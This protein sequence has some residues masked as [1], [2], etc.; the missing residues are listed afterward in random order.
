MLPMN[1]ATAISTNLVGA[2]GFITLLLVAISGAYGVIVELAS[3][4]ESFHYAELLRK[5]FKP[6]RVI[7]A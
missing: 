1:V 2:L 7:D 4:A 3:W 5:R 6:G